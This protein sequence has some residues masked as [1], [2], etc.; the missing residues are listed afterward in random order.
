MNPIIN[1]ITP[2][3]GSIFLYGTF[4]D[5]IASFT[6]LNGEQNETFSYGWKIF[7]ING[8]VDISKDAFK[9]YY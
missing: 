7:Q 5:L 8:N 9:T 6:M 3:D 4:V 2:E 1:Y